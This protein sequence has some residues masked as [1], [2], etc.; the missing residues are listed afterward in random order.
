MLPFIQA[1]EIKYAVAE[2]LKST[3][4]FADNRL[5]QA[6]EDLLHDSHQGMFKGPYM[7]L[8]LPFEKMQKGTA[9]EET[10]YIRP[11]FDPYQHQYEAFC[12]LSSRGGH[13][14]EPVILTTGTGSGKTES[15]LFPLL[16]YCHANRERMGI[17]AIIL[18]PM[19]A[20]AT[21]QARR[22]AEEIHK[23]KDEAGN[24][25][26]R[27]TIRAGLF[28]GEGRD[29]GKIRPTRM[30][31]DHI[32]E[33]RDTLLKSPPDIL[34]TNFKMLDFALMQ[35]RFQSLWR[36]NLQAGNHNLLQYLVLDELHTYDGAKGSD[37]ANLIR[38][39]KLKLHTDTIT[40][41]GTSATMAGGESGKQQLVKFCSDVFGVDI[42]LSSIIEENR[43]DADS[44][45]D[46]ELHT[47]HIDLAHTQTCTFGEDDNYQSYVD[48]Q[49][50]YWG[51]AGLTP[52]QLGT[53]LRQNRWLAELL[54]ITQSEVVEIDKTLSRWAERTGLDTLHR[55]QQKNIFHSLLTLVVYAKEQS[56]SKQFPFLYLQITYWAR[57]LTRMVRKLQQTPAF[58]WENDL[59]PSDPVVNLP[60]YYCR[61]CGATGWIG[62][63]KENSDTFENDLVRTRKLFMADGQNKNIYLISSLAGGLLTTDVADEEYIEA[64]AGKTEAYMHPHSLTLEEKRPRHTPEADDYFKVVLFRRQLDDRIEKR[65]P[66]CNTLNTMA[67]IGTGLPTIES[68]ATAQILSTATDNATNQN[69]KLL[70]FTNGVQDAAHQ[71]GFIENRNYRFG[72]RHA[73][74][75]ALKQEEERISLPDFYRAFE[76]YWKQAA[77]DE[78]TGTLMPYYYKFLPPDC[79]NNI[80]IRDYHTKAGKF[81]PEF[82]REFTHRISWEIWA[83]YSYNSILGR[84]LEKSGASGISYDMETL[85]DIYRQMQGWLH[86]NHLDTRMEERTFLNFLGGFLYRLRTR[87]AVDHPYLR[88]YRNEKSNYWLI[89]QSAN[90]NHFLIRNFGKSTRLPRFITYEK[91]KNT[92]TFDVIR[93]EN[94]RNWYFDY[95]VK[96]F[97]MVHPEAETGLINDFYKVLIDYLEANQ[98]FNKKIATGVL[99]Y[100][101]A[102]EQIYLTRHIHAYTC[103]ECR[104]TL[105]A[106]AD[107]AEL[108]QEMSCIRHRCTGHYTRSETAPFDYYRLVYNRGRSVRIYARDHT[109]LID[110]NKREKLEYD[111]KKHPHFNSTNVLVA[112]ST[113]EMGIDIGDLNVTFNSSLPPETANYIQRVGRAG[114]SSGTSLIFNITGGDE[115]DLYYFQDPLNMMNGQVKTP[116]CY[117]EAKDILTRH[118]MAYCFDRWAGLNPAENNIPPIV[119]ALRLKSLPLGNGQF[120]FNRIAGYIDNNKEEILTT[121][122]TCYPEKMQQREAIQELREMLASGALVKRI[123]D[124][125]AN[126]LEELSYYDQKL[127]EIKKTLSTLPG[128]GIESNA[129]KKEQRALAQARFNIDNRNT[130][131]YLTNIGILPNYAFPETGVFF[132]AQIISSKKQD[133]NQITYTSERFD[134]IVRPASSALTELAPANYFYTQGYKLESQGLEVRSEGEYQ[135]YRFCS[136]CDHI[137]LNADADSSQTH[138]PKCNN[139]S[140][141]SLRNIKTMVRLTSVTS[142]CQKERARITDASDDRDRKFY[143]RSVHI[144][145]N[146]RYS[147]GAKVLKRVPFGIEFFT[148]T[149]YIDINTGVREEN[150]FGGRKLTINGEDHSEAGFVICRTCGKTAERTLTDYEI[151]KG[152]KTY[153][154][155]YCANRER[156]YQG[157]E[158]DCFREIY[159][160]RNF[161]TE[162]LKILLPVQDFRTQEKIAVFK[163]GLYLGLKDY[164]KGHPD[165]IYIRE[166]LEHNRN[167]GHKETYL[168]MYESI[169]GGTGY[170]SRLFDTQ[171]FTE[172]LR[173]AYEHI[174]H[175][176]CKDEGK[177]GCYKCIYTYGNQYERAT[178]SRNEAEELFRNILD[179]AGEWKQADS[180]SGISEFANNEESELEGLFIDH[181][182][183]KYRHT[184]HSNFVRKSEEGIKTYELTLTQGEGNRIV[185]QILPQNEGRNLAGVK[186]TTR[187][188]FL[189]RC[190]S[191]TRNQQPASL[192]EVENIKDIVVYLDGYQYHATKEHART[193]TDLRIREAIL[194]SGKYQLW[195]FTWADIVEYL[196]KNEKDPL[197]QA[198]TE[199]I[200]VRMLNKHPRV[201]QSNL[202][203]SH[204]QALHSFER[205]ELLLHAPIRQV[206]F[207]LW[208]ALYLY[209]CQQQL[210]GQCYTEAHVQQFRAAKRIDP[211]QAEA[212]N[213]TQYAYAD[214]LKFNDELGLHLFI[215]SQKMEVESFCTHNP[216]LQEWEKDNWRFF[217]QVFNLVQFH[218]YTGIEQEKPGV[219]ATN[220][221]E[222][223]L[224]NFHPDLHSIVK[225]LLD[226]SIPIN[227]EFDFDLLHEGEIIASAELGAHQ[228]KFF[229]RPFDED[230]RQHFLR[231]GY[232][233]YTTENFDIN[234]LKP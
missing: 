215:H 29:K 196:K 62:W 207:T 213:P 82:T 220:A 30:G 97:P 85:K 84:T 8:R 13:T 81:K 187:P 110:R 115:H 90:K 77:D 151:N 180:L 210:L 130:I 9:L 174:R 57:S 20:L 56:G 69:R 200:L 230:A 140:W 26:L 219:A 98:L 229:L 142:N 21:D 59:N 147:K 50:A 54:R 144:K 175:C 178:L 141:G 154:F 87:G 224:E 198:I 94:N 146:P 91:G 74:Q 186:Y 106:G 35:G 150:Y 197:R 102:P 152:I 66:H 95:F 109:G 166:Y 80:D 101:I 63:K 32:I 41:V 86:E 33:D 22:L 145:T 188:D 176:T 99:N 129:L 76:I 88:K 113:L 16:D 93:K 217:W 108:Y 71:A 10:L 149:Q 79:E 17:K 189:I 202:Q 23:W 128:T 28:I 43:K 111:F 138:C 191:L 112:T 1:E 65:C 124:I 34:L 169:P 25:I 127:K 164:F 221:I 125:H 52:A 184:A 193:L 105:H 12:R 225:Q 148:K 75:T 165:H 92:S 143:Q 153:H 162:A 218:P 83:E 123:T 46:A 177:D 47:P 49:L 233:E 134:E 116:A 37:V 107:N 223:V 161:T 139:V 203:T 40:P 6:F 205:F 72:L 24:P 167:T 155:H 222:E 70:A 163:A 117:L 209:A 226:V 121:F 27:D 192:R 55:E 60:P 5:E 3:Y 216:L 19:N 206:D 170:L 48:R 64:G 73:I 190:I 171:E 38:R 7:Q 15:F 14:P 44:F 78:N 51:Y 31:A 39:L 58:A 11:P 168:V 172:L 185:Y 36:H 211:G 195:I 53:A 182:E 214:K 122:L 118:F 89:T 194:H 120:V 119:K 183:K 42:R 67:L 45:F 135:E 201:K 173:A 137:A 199:P 4:N 126:L 232:V 181:L 104:H 212:N 96:T 179:K 158:D 157:A 2:Y 103:S 227:T 68:V 234:P 114:R 231:E 159:L 131:E 100:G 132:N 204:F 228:P 160:Y 133:N 208:S 156:Q 18:Y 61:E 136:Q